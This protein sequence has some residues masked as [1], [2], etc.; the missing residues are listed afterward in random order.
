LK[1]ASRAV[2]A[3]VLLFQIF[4]TSLVAREPAQTKEQLTN[5]LEESRRKNDL[6]GE[7]VALLRLGIA[8]WE[9][10]HAD[11]ARA[12]LTEAAGKMSAQNDVVG[13]WFA[14]FTLSELEDLSG[15]RKEAIQYVER[16]LS[17]INDAKMST[18][19]FSLETLFTLWDS[20]QPRGMLE[21]YQYFEDWMKPMV[22]EGM[23]EPI[24]RDS[25]GG[26]LMDAGQLERAEEELNRAADCLK[27][28]PV[29]YHGLE[30]H[31]GD[32]RFRQKR[33]DEAAA[34]YRSG[35]EASSQTPQDPMEDSRTRL[36][37]YN[38]LALAEASAG[39]SEEA[40]QWREKASDVEHAFMER[41]EGA[42]M[43]ATDA[44][45]TTSGERAP[46]TEVGLMKALNAVKAVKSV[47]A[48]AA[49]ELSQGRASLLNGNYGSAAAHL[50]RALQL[51]QSLNDPLS[52]MAAWE[53]LCIVYLHTSNY[54]AMENALNRAH[55]RI[56]MGKQE[57]IDDSF[58]W[59]E[60]WLRFKRGQA[61]V[62]DVQASMERTMRHASVTS[63][64]RVQELRPI[65]EH[66]LKMLETKD[67][68]GIERRFDDTVEGQY[69]AVMAG[70]QE[71][72]KGNM[73]GARKLLQEVA[74]TSA[75]SEAR[76]TLLLIIGASYM[77]QFD[78]DEASRA[79]ADGLEALEIGSDDMRSESMLT[80]YLGDTRLY[81]DT[82]LQSQ[83]WF[84]KIAEGFET[85]E[86][87]R[88]R[89]FLRLLG[90]R[91]LKL[92]G[93]EGSSLVKEADALRRKI[94]DWDEESQHDGSLAK[95]R[96]QYE[97]LLPRV[98][99]SAPEYASLTGVPSQSIQAVQEELPEDT[100]LLSYFITPLGAHAWILDKDSLD[101]VQ[102]LVSESEL[103]R[104]SCWAFEL[105]RPR[106]ARPFG[107][108]E[109]SAGSANA[110]EAYAA[111]IEPLRSKIRRRRLMIIPHGELHYVP[112]AALYDEK[113]E[114]YLVQ[115][116]PITYMPSAS[117]IPFLRQKDSPVGG[118]ALVLGDPATPSQPPLPGAAKE[119]RL[120]AEKLH[121]R[122]KLGK[123][124]QES[125]LYRLDGKVD[126]LHIAAHGT[127]D[128]ASPLFSAIHLAQGNG[129]N[130]QL[131]VDEIQSRLDLSGVNLV[132]FSA[133][134]SGVGN[135]SEG[136]E[137]VG[138]TRS[139]LYAG[140]P[141][142]IATLWDISD[143]ATP[144]LIGKFYD[145]LLAGASAAE[146]LR[147]AQV[148]MIGDPQFADPR[149]WAAF[150]LAG[151][152]RGR[153]SRQQSSSPHRAQ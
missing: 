123:D 33:Y 141:G 66:M 5:T 65:A 63:P 73:E 106:G 56:E 99:A 15:R 143:E 135:R 9:L 31:L 112:F 79:F 117:S 82:V 96:Q 122:A 119:A 53:S 83:L 91:R 47:A 72:Q 40:K 64:D 80:R 57:I 87:A 37:Y 34:H 22:L 103:K 71:F 147:A 129:E 86:R 113:C 114:R 92:P 13:A 85:S 21:L 95:L 94:A 23:L 24:T 108:H 127:Y 118:V 50:E 29:P 75:N 70:M 12:D 19:S 142:V 97:A 28:S 128:A 8:E 126:L 145:H 124:A 89:T 111:L 116:F 100:T 130:G 60:T 25:Y 77:M 146:A 84:G 30:V 55:Q 110:A 151:D 107:D 68:S 2:I 51:H 134:R 45:L 121:T 48:D 93:G 52:E 20:G 26:L 69:T 17:V 38:R 6:R 41:P 59:L 120:V 3:V 102:L 150:F 88:A 11:A 32:L 62:K 139:I 44:Q 76:S 132:V 152:P 115:D 39:H 58:T 61:T 27:D 49:L 81:Y 133:C 36:E 140:S 109:C 144:P 137:I 43:M 1:V 16:A 105:A 125:L 46:E 7:A 138:L 90:N 74:E 136:D 42:A 131:N 35:L 153:W 18:A 104:I 54:A 148:E 67:V 101:Y 149:Y 10:D 4:A 98:Q 78:Y 14:F